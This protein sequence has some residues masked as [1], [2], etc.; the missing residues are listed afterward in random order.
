MNLHEL[1]LATGLPA[2]TIRFYAAEGI[3][4]AAGEKPG[5]NNYPPEAVTVLKKVVFLRKMGIPL[6]EIRAYK[7]GFRNLS[8]LLDALPEEDESSVGLLQKLKEENP[9]FEVLNEEALGTFWKAKDPQ[10]KGNRGV[11]GDSFTPLYAPW[12]RYLARMLDLSLYSLLWNAFLVYGLHWNLLNQ[13]LGRRV[14]D[15]LITAGFMLL[16]EPLFLSKWGTT[17]GKALLGMRLRNR[18]GNLLSYNEAF[19]R[20]LTVFHKGM[21]LNIPFYNFYTLIKAYQ[22]AKDEQPQ[23][24]DD[25]ALYTMKEPRIIQG[26]LL[27][28]ANVAVFFL[29]LVLILSQRIPPNRGNLTV[30]EFVE[31]FNYYVQYYDVDLG[32]QVL[33]N[34][35]TWVK[36]E[37]QGV[38]ILDPWEGHMPQFTFDLEGEKVKGV[39]TRVAYQGKDTWL[40]P[41]DNLNIMTALALTGAQKNVGLFS[42]LPDNVADAISQFPYGPYDFVKGGIRF[43]AD[44]RI[45]GYQI[46]TSGYLVPLPEAKVY[47]FW[48]NFSVALP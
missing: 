32:G 47:D 33:K 23:V 29:I 8:A 22:R 20:T 44:S 1:E 40:A 36:E 46:Y 17:P 26:V 2:E 16:L 27:A 3:L 13:T 9:D 24:W 43:L 7:G 15:V 28:G 25:Q 30:P 18:E 38:F 35:G 45:T 34:D 12:R 4:G 39:S 37:I 21:G 42:R 48:L 19:D 11:P 41:Y 6:S 31:N 10:S 5:Q 14:L